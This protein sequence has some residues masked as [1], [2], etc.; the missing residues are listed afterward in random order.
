MESFIY[1]S[2]EFRNNLQQ[3]PHAA[4]EVKL[5]GSIAGPGMNVIDVGANKGVTT[6]AIAKKVGKT[7]HVYAFEPI[8]EYYAALMENLSG[9]GVENAS[10]YQWALSNHIGHITLYKHGEGS[11][12]T[13][14]E[15]A[16]ELLV[17]STTIDD[18]RHEMGI[19]T[20]DVINMDCEGSELFV[21][22]GAET[23]L[24]TERPYIFCEIHHEYLKKLGQSVRDIVNYLEQLCFKIKP[25]LVEDSDRAA[26][27]EDCSHLCAHGTGQ[28]KGVDSPAKSLE[29]KIGDLKAR[30]PAHSVRPSILQ[31]LEELEDKFKRAK[32]KTVARAHNIGGRTE[33]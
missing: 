33:R 21:L 29:K 16:E 25:V 18:F 28:P 11:G 23:T 22:Q 2:D 32:G 30:L 1:G 4:G 5:L 31:E 7:G 10:A 27:L 12:I 13:P 8:P 14:E 26:C 19:K 20:V 9:N 6:V 15:G 3:S 17:Q 24:R